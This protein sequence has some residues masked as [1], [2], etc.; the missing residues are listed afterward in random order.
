VN[1]QVVWD[2]VAGKPG[3]VRDVVTLNA[4]AA[5]VAYAKPVAGR[6][7]MGPPRRAARARLDRDRAPRPT[8]WSSG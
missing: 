2:L 4:A 6:D 8:W 5:L 3:P 1:A 7:K